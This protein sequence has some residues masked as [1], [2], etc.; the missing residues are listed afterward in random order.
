MLVDPACGLSQMIRLLT[1]QEIQEIFAVLLEIHLLAWIYTFKVR[2]FLLQLMMESSNVACLVIVPYSSQLIYS[3]NASIFCAKLIILM[4]FIIGFVQI[5]S[6]YVDLPTDMIVYPQEYTLHC[7]KTGYYGGYS[8]RIQLGSSIVCSQCIRK[9][10]HSKNHTYDHTITI[11][12]NGETV[13]SSGSFHQ[14]IIGDQHYWCK[15]GVAGVIRTQ[16]VIMKGKITY[17]N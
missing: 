13:S 7:V 2:N 4:L 8:S 11:T 10:L 12:W 3:V 9:E 15:I 6:F 14:T 16:D 1:V 17:K 5:S